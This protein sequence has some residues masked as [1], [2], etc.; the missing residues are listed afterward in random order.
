MSIYNVCWSGFAMKSDVVGCGCSIRC[1]CN[2]YSQFPILSE[3]SNLI[4][5]GVVTDQRWTGQEEL[6]EKDIS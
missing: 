3:T 6:G 5:L 2:Y 1:N 4:P